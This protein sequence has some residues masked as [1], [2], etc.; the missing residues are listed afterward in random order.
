VVEQGAG[1]VK[2]MLGFSGSSDRQLT[3]C[4][5]NAAIG[6]TIKLLGDRF[7]REVE[8]QFSP[9]GSLPKA[10]ASKDFI[11]QVLLN[12]IFNAAEAM[13]G[14]RQVILS[15][16]QAGQLPPGLVLAP[17]A[18]STYVLVSVK[19]FGTG[20]A[21]EVLPRIFEP[22]FTT[23]SL[24]ARRGTGLGLSM[25]YE[26]AQQ[27]DAGIAVVSEPGRGSMFTLILAVRDLPVDISK[28]KE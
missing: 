1:I 19:D 23:K 6:E 24:S 11:R 9:V 5:A 14:K 26:L 8:V 12:L 21:P 25:V 18:A 20:I 28:P 16:A 3:M 2:A 4:D 22:F 13:A 10:P 15:A 17:P 27:M 7:L